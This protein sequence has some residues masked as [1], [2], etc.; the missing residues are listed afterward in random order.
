M[1]ASGGGTDNLAVASSKTS[2]EAEMEERVG[3]VIIGG[4]IV[5]CAVAYYLTEQGESDILLVEQNELASGS[6]GGS[7][8]GVRQQFS[9]PLEVELSRRGL[10]FWRSAG[11]VFEAPVPFQPCGYLFVTGQPEIMDRLRAAAALQGAMGLTDVHLL[12]AD[13]LVQAAPWLSPEG[14]IGGCWTPSDGRVNPPDGVAALARAATAAGVTIREHWR[15][16]SLRRAN[17][18]WL[19]T[20]RGEVEASRVVACT[21]YW[22][23]ELLR[24]LGLELTI[25]PV[26]LL[27]AITEPALGGQPVPLTI[28]L[29]TGLFVE[30]EGRALWIAV[31]LEEPP[32]GWSHQ[33]M[34]AAYGELASTRAPALADLKVARFTTGMVDYGGDGHP[35]VGEVEEGLWMA[36]GFGGHG[37]MHGPP[38]AALLA[39]AIAGR[40]DPELDITPLSPWRTAGGEP[41]WMVAAKKG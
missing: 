12:E 4:G 27:G 15:V 14:L 17:G 20:G 32:P 1:V 2:L 11:R 39:R 21:G 29:D 16:G 41:E 8:G 34:L 23:S 13:G 10:E 36:A 5:G 24:P 9:T 35:Y 37:T 28:D 38:V 26:P 40:P 22:S 3:T 31:L 19:V 18:R 7:N 6:T 30:P 25:R 33:Q